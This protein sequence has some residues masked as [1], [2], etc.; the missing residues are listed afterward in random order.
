MWETAI[1]HDPGTEA[2]ATTAHDAR[3][4]ST[5]IPLFDLAQGVALTPPTILQ[6][7]PVGAINKRGQAHPIN[8][9]PDEIERRIRKRSFPEHAAPYNRFFPVDEGSTMRRKE[10][11]NDGGRLI[12][13]P[14]RRRTS[15]AR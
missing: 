14:A 15:A 1:R 11:R 3:L 4:R 13:I 6:N 9:R 7:A 8:Q 2:D 10:L 5:A 12:T